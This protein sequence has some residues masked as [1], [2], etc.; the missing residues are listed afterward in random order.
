MLDRRFNIATL[1]ACNRVLPCGFDVSDNAPDT[2]EGLCAHY[3]K[4]GRILVWS[5]ASDKTI[6]GD[7]EI[8]YA[9][10]AWHDASHIRGGFD[11]SLS[12]EIQTAGL[13]AL[14]LMSIYGKGKAYDAFERL[15]FAEII[16]QAL[17]ER[18][19]GGFPIDQIGFA[20]CYLRNKTEALH[21]SAIFG[22]C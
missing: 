22:V 5:G 9:F 2:F 11:F 3:E 10:R 4:T 18:A 16:G 8:N 12:G 7:C 19:N 14:D 17:Y 20:R 1:H 6:F 21:S 15:L 13:Q